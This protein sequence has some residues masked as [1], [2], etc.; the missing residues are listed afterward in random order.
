MDNNP[1]ID[2]LTGLLF[3][4]NVISLPLLYIL[5][6]QE[7]VEQRRNR[8][9]KERYASLSEEE[10][11]RRQRKIPV[12]SLPLPEESPWYQ[13][14]IAKQDQAFLTTCG[15]D[16]EHFMDL[17]K[18]FQPIFD[19]HSPH[20]TPDDG[21]C[22]RELSDTERRGRPRKVTAHAC[23]ALALFWTG[24]MPARSKI[25]SNVFYIINFFDG[26]SV[27]LNVCRRANTSARRQ[28]KFSKFHLFFYLSQPIC[29]I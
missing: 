5:S 19:T 11:S 20:S 14:Y 10:R 29:E 3:L 7:T 21:G 27:S 28:T 22:V 16:V 18:D 25:R 1:Q 17:L 12:A 9:R 13:I 24:T 15:L 26:R 2:A 23:M 4:Q 8:K 6:N